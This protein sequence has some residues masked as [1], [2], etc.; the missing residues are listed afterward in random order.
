MSG[1]N[2]QYCASDVVVFVRMG[3]SYDDDDAFDGFV[4]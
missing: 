2:H 4:P 1:L 3:S